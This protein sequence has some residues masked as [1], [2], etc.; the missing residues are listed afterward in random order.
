MSIEENLKSIADSLKEL[1]QIGRLNL[2]LMAAQNSEGKTS[3]S[4]PP[5]SGASEPAQTEPS[6]S[7]AVTSDSASAPKRKGRPPKAA[8]ASSPPVEPE[9]VA[10]P[11]PEPAAVATPAVE[12]PTVV[13]ETRPEPEPV[14]D[15]LD[16]DKLVQFP[17]PTS[18]NVRKALIDYAAR[19]GGSE[20]NQG[21]RAKARALMKQ[22]TGCEVMPQLDALVKAKGSTE[23][24]AAVIKAAMEG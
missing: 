7:P 4:T 3:P 19:N 6:P 8:P 13:V 23:P 21:G 20:P 16:D 11:E 18:E 9:P 12:P 2:A 22:V 5:S 14:D 15:F 1:T 10:T 24:Y 17:E